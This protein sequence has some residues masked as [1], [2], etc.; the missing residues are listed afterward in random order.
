MDWDFRWEVQYFEN[1]E[2]RQIIVLTA[3]LVKEIRTVLD[4]SEVFRWGDATIE[5]KMRNVWNMSK[6]FGDIP[7]R[8]ASSMGDTH[9]DAQCTLRS[10]ELLGDEGTKV[11]RLHL[12]PDMNIQANKGRGADKFEKLD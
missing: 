4:P 9:R 2:V 3:Q 12:V 6:E 7:P 8:V 11:F 1:L 10:G 5:C